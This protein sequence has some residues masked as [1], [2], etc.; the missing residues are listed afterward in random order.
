MCRLVS[1]SSWLFTWAGASL[2]ILSLLMTPTNA[3]SDGGGGDNP[4]GCSDCP[5]C[6][7]VNT[8]CCTSTTPGCK[9]IIGGCDNSSP[10]FDCRGCFC[11]DP[12]FGGTK[13]GCL[14]Q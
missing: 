6:G 3:L 11:T 8:N 7:S 14:P 2:L 4:G 12:Q 13:C 5:K 10:G 1:V 9:D